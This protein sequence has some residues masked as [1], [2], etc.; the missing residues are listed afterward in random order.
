[1]IGSQAFTAVPRGITSHQWQLLYL[2]C[3]TLA[4]PIFSP[5]FCSVTLPLNSCSSIPTF[6]LFLLSIFESQLY[7]YK[8]RLERNCLSVEV[9]LLQGLHFLLTSYFLI[10]VWGE[11]TL[12]GRA[13][14]P[15]G[16][17]ALGACVGVGVDGW[18]FCISLLPE[19]LI[20]SGKLP[21][22]QSVYLFTT[23]KVI[24]LTFGNQDHTSCWKQCTFQ[25]KR[26]LSR[27]WVS[28]W[29]SFITFSLF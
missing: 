20:N 13:I 19:D 15:L 5:L 6:N 1:M 14:P 18:G 24:Y 16:I 29:R 21:R 23:L 7:F 17:N 4:C 8:V 27:W 10:M 28:S 25:H 3:V 12:N 9:H 2:C 11:I 22:H 26:W